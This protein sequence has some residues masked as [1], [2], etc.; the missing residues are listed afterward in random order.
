MRQR[1]KTREVLKP[2]NRNSEG[3]SREDRDG[4]ADAER[5]WRGASKDNKRGV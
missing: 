4:K 3:E 2:G 5:M 1:G